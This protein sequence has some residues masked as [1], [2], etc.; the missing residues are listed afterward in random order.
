MPGE[1]TRDGGA[2]AMARIAADMGMT[3]TA[4]SMATTAIDRTAAAPKPDVVVDKG[5]SV[6]L[7]T[8]KSPS[9]KEK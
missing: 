1:I 4:M 3:A 6:E 9:E 2:A 5:L 7:S 8:K